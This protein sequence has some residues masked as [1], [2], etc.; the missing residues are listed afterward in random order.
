MCNVGEFQSCKS[1]IIKCIEA[2]AGESI[3]AGVACALDTCYLL[4]KEETVSDDNGRFIRAV[5]T[6]VRILLF[7]EYA[8]VC[9]SVC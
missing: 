5:V 7:A 1:S 9:C 8:L 6:S 2:Q 4:M 3:R